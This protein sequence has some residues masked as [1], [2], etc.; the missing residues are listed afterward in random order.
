MTFQPNTSNDDKSDSADNIARGDSL[1]KSLAQKYKLTQEGTEWLK[2]ALDPFPDETR[3]IP[4]FPDM[5]SSKSIRYPIKIETQ[6]TDGGL[7]VPWDCNI[8]FQG[9]FG[10][11]KLRV[12]TR[13]RLTF[14]SG[15]QGAT[16]YDVGG[17]QIRRIGAGGATPCSTIV[18]NLLPSMPV[19][20]FRV[21]SMGVEVQNQTEP[22]YRS[23]GS[24]AYRMPSVPL[25]K[26]ICN[27]STVTTAAGTPNM[28]HELR[29]LPLTTAEALNLPDSVEDAAENGAYM[30]A[31]MDGPVNE[32]NQ[33]VSG[34]F[35]PA[36]FLLSQAV[37]YFPQIQGAAL[38]FNVANTSNSRIPY[39]SFGVF[40][41]NLSSQ[42]KLKV[43]LHA[44]IE[45]FPPPSSTLLTA[46]ASRSANY[47]PEALV[48]YSR[49]V[50]TLPIS[51][52]ARDNFL[53]SFFLE[54]AKSIAAW[55][56][57]KL[58]KGWDKTEK[59]KE[60]DEIKDEL[61]VIKEMRKLE[62]EERM[63]A[64]S[65]AV[66]VKPN[67]PPTIVR[68]NNPKPPSLPPRD[69]KVIKE[70]HRPGDKKWTKNPQAK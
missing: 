55:A 46:L 37:T 14:Q 60:L 18:Q 69:Y 54:A 50:R 34:S 63:R 28:M 15:G 49:A 4:G 59:D 61:K 41:N 38:P 7:G 24:V 31:I 58:L 10:T 70:V 36:P 32:P 3:S 66:L 43:I 35:A 44:F 51:V 21:V 39:N 6:V 68:T 1:F 23:G 57:P 8:A 65:R 29:E 45:E 56:A 67:A 22:L 16:D 62:L 13:D 26:Q 27:I 33:S 53:G 40:F 42:T 17:V 47:D 25:E 52:P 11:N 2:T 12:T 64:P 19:N 5:I 30:V 20:P 48:L 9:L